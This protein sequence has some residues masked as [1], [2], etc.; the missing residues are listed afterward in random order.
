M[1]EQ[2][3]KERYLPDWVCLERQSIR[4]K[5]GEGGQANGFRDVFLLC[6]SNLGGLYERLVY[7]SA[8]VFQSVAVPAR[9]G[10]RLLRQV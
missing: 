1:V 7:P 9:L 5:N 6:L 4:R 10:R 8:F 3:A 2:V